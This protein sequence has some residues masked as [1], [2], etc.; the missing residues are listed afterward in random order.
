MNRLFA[1]AFKVLD[2]KFGCSYN[3]TDS[4]TVNFDKF[5]KFISYAVVFCGFL[6]LWV[7]GGAG[8]AVSVFFLTVLIASWF[9]ENSRWQI[10]EKVGT[11]LMFCLIP[12]FY[13]DWKYKFTGFGNTETMLVGIL[14]RLILLLA[15][16]KLFQKKGDRDWLFLY[17]MSFFEVLLAAGVSISPLF[18]ASLI[19]YLL[20]VLCAIITFEIR[21]TSRLVAPKAANEKLPADEVK[22]ALKNKLITRLPSTA[23][24]LLILIMVVGTPLFFALP[25][26]GN[27]GKGNNQ[28]AFSSITGFSDSVRLGDI[29]QLKQSEEIV[30]RARLENVRGN[31]L[32]TARWRGVA[33]DFFDNRTWSK[34]TDFGRDLKL[35]S[36]FFRI[37]Y[38]RDTESIVAQTIYLEPIDTPVLFTLSRPLA[39][40]GNFQSLREDSHKAINFTRNEFDRL[41]YKVY[42]DTSMPDLSR[43]REDNES[44]PPDK[45]RY[46]QL[47][48]KFDERISQL[49]SELTRDKTNRFDRAVAV[50]KYL[51]N[52]FGYTLDL[53]AGGEE[54]LADFLFNV[55][56]GHCEYFASAMAVMLR[57]QGI[58]TRVING[59]QLG[60][61]NETADVYVVKQK[62]AHTWVEV[63]FPGENAWIPFDPTPYAGQTDGMVSSG[64]FSS[65]NQY[66]EALETFWIQYFVA[67]DSQEQRSL[68]RSFKNSFQG[69]QAKTSDWLNRQQDRIGD[70]WKDVRG[71]KG[72]Q[73][74]AFA[75]AYGIGYLAGL[76]LSIFLLVWLYRKISRSSA[77]QKF[78]A[79]LRQ[80]KDTTIVEFYDRMQ[81]ILASKGLRREDHQTPLEFAFALGM[82]EA[83]KVTEKYHRVRFGEKDLS[84]EEA[85]EIED[86]LKNLESKET[87]S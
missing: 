78:A 47:P 79:W 5:F 83:V 53:K 10:S 18:L 46:L 77:W 36:G 50:E 62:S 37:D 61:Y 84:S 27:A 48:E 72:L 17:L 58:A 34:K 56:E 6:T 26:V 65:F 30:M 86:W 45:E 74:S 81:N 71:D 20:T 4:T 33:L 14:A 39:V 29:G 35:E 8:L 59:F 7:S 19:L 44:Y 69:V 73:T 43:L 68:F 22:A 76:A 75:L 23:V 57:T 51:Q 66:V 82:P 13:F 70:W 21:K 40:Q 11:A 80:R 16:I 9:L 32:N 41:I 12:L 42:S 55:R 85:A 38:A 63:Y 67:Y 54:P 28:S 15:A 87:K 2:N 64:I 24:I 52:E 31:N 25:R 3:Q 60:E 1:F 49:A